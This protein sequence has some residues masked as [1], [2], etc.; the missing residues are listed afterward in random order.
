MFISKYSCYL[1]VMCI[2]CEVFIIENY[3]GWFYYSVN[4]VLK[5]DNQFVGF[6]IS[7]GC[8]FRKIMS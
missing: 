4:I 7:V 3:E 6:E 5:C 2:F 8:I 1:V